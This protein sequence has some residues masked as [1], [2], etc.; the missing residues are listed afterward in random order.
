MAHGDT[1]DW[2]LPDVSSQMIL[3]QLLP[4]LQKS[5]RFGNGGVW[6][7]TQ[8]CDA[9]FASIN[10]PAV[11]P[12]AAL[13]A[14][15]MSDPVQKLMTIHRPR[16]PKSKVVHMRLDPAEFTRTETAAR[17]AGMTVSAFIRSLTLEGAGVCPFFT[18]EDHLLLG[19]IMIDLKS[20]RASLQLLLRSEPRAEGLRPVDEQAVIE[21]VQRVVAALCFEIGFFAR[22]AIHRRRGAL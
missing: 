22:Q 12:P 9:I 14:I 5:H 6:Q 3:R 18:E 11:D 15:S 4:R 19:A 7:D 21:D 13:K 17:D 2:Q 20:V 1:S 16:V 10:G 8:N